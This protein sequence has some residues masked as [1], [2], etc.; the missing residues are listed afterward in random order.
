[1][2]T[3]TFVVARTDA[4]AATLLNSNVDPRDHPFILGSTNPEQ[5]GLNDEVLNAEK[6]GAGQ[7]ELVDITTKWDQKAGL[8]T[9]GQAVIKALDAKGLKEKAKEFQAKERSF[10]NLEA[11]AYAKSL[12]V[13]PY[14]CWDKPR[15]REGYYRFD[16]GIEAC[17]VRGIAYAE[18]C[19]LMW[20]ETKK[21]TAH[22]DTH[23]R[24]PVRLCLHVLTLHSLVVSLCVSPS[25]PLRRC[26]LL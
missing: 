16:G 5:L 4:E 11:R 24:S 8:C 12:G 22:N 17:I 13:D 19:D 14:W 7:A 21:R 23:M 15:A 1:M 6:R 26:P 18:Y 3:E 25:D 10:S 9:Y 2:G 20:M